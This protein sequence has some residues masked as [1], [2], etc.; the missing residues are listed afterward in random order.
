[1]LDSGGFTQLF[2]H[3]KWTI[4]QA[5]YAELVN[6]IVP[7]IG[8]CVA[9]AVQDWMCEPYILQ[10]TG[11]TVE[12]HQRRTV[13]SYVA[14]AHTHT[15]PW[16]PILQGWT[17]A[18]YHKHIEMYD[19]AGVDLRAFDVVGIGTMCRRQGT[20][21]ATE[22]I[23]SVARCGIKLHGF[24]FKITGLGDVCNELVSADSMAWSLTARK[25]KPL[26]GCM[27]KHCGNCIKYATRWY[28]RVNNICR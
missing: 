23:K 5:E 11:L 22:I 12:E 19:K 13:E 18:D 8:K 15:Q 16:M 6:R 17:E 1:M 28:E 24:G 7:A 4:T 26:E 2:L 25:G 3:G 21:E 10:K 9:V 14:L 27:H 20:K